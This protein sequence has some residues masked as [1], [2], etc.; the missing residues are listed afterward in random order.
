MVTGNAVCL[1]C[2]YDMTGLPVPGACPECGAYVWLESMDQRRSLS[3]SIAGRCL[4]LAATASGAGGVIGIILYLSGWKQWSTAT[5]VGAALMEWSIIL[6]IVVDIIA[7]TWVLTVPEKDRPA[8][9]CVVLLNITALIVG[10]LA[11]AKGYA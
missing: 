11:P 2:G 1:K 10:I 4:K 9:T 6:L 5:I 3:G 7:A 8:V